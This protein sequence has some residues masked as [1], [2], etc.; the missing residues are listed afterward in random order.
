MA[1]FSYPSKLA[2]RQQMPDQTHHSVILGLYTGLINPIGGNHEKQL[3]ALLAAILMLVTSANA[4]FYQNS[5][6]VSNATTSSRVSASSSTADQAQISQLQRLV[7]HQ[8][9]TVQPSHLHNFH[10]VFCYTFHE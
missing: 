3:P 2:Q 4:L 5:A 6:E 7:Q 8:P 10:I 1:D 9:P